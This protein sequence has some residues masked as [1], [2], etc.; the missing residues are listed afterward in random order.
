MRKLAK[1]MAQGDPGRPRRIGQR[2]RRPLQKVVHRPLGKL[3][4]PALHLALELVGDDADHAAGLPG[5]DDAGRAIQ[6]YCDLVARSAIDGISRASGDQ[7]VDL[8]AAEAPVLVEEALAEPAAADAGVAFELLTAPR[9]APD[10]LTKLSGAG[11]DA[12]QKLNDGGIFRYL[13][14]PWNPQE[15]AFTLRQ[16]AEIFERQK[17][18]VAEAFAIP[19]LDIRALSDLAGRDSRFD[20]A[21][22]VSEVAGS[23]ARILRHLLPVL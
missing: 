10:D 23:S 2:R 15:M 9:G 14:K 11:P 8:G 18:Q 12:V 22:F 7:G 17:G 13:T 6:L 5:N 4:R 3:A 16:A 19:F 20:F 1:S 21:T